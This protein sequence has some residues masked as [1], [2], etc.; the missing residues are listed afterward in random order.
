MCSF[1]IRC[2]LNNFRMCTAEDSCNDLQGIVYA[3][4]LKKVS[5]YK[6]TSLVSKKVRGVSLFELCSS[7]EDSCN[8]YVKGKVIP[9]QARCGPEGSRRFRLPDFHDIWHMKV[10]RCN[11]YV[12]L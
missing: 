2:L 7:L 3:I 9:L 11:E 4:F 6:V 10:V 1:F 12:L 5:S 8:E